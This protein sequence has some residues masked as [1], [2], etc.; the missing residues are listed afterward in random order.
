MP[1]RKSLNDLVLTLT[2]AVWNFDSNVSMIRFFFFF[3]D[4]ALCQQFPVLVKHYS[5]TIF[6]LLAQ[7]PMDLGNV[8]K[9]ISVSDF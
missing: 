5:I 6:V 1:L 2:F 4:S 7:V 8:S 3:Q 9:F